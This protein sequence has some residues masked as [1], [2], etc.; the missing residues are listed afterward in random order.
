MSNQ[1]QVKIGPKFFQNEKRAYNSHKDALIRELIQ[2][3]V[4][5]KYSTKIHFTVN[6]DE[7]TISDNGTGMSRETL[8]KVFMNLGETTKVGE[9][10]CG[11]FG[12]ARNLICFAQEGYTIISDDYIV[13]GCGA[14]Y[15]I[16]DAPKSNG[17][18]F[19]IKTG[20]SA[21]WEERIKKILNKCSPRQTIYLNGEEIKNDRHRGRHIRNFSFGA[22]YVNHSDK[23]NSVDVRSNGVWMFSNYCDVPATIYVEVNP[24]ISKTVFTSNRDGLQ[25]EY[26]KE[27]NAFLKELATE[28]LSA[29][30]VKNRTF[31][32]FMKKGMGF[33]VRP[34]KKQTK[35]VGFEEFAKLAAFATDRAAINAADVNFGERYLETPVV[36]LLPV[37]KEDSMIKCS[38]LV[39]EIND[40]RIARIVE[41]F[42][43]EF[44][45][46]NE[47]RYKLLKVWEVI[48]R[49]VA[50]EYAELT[51]EEVVFGIGWIFKSGTVAQMRVEENMRYLLINPIDEE[52]KIKYSTV[53]RDDLIELIMTAIHECSHFASEGGY[54]DEIFA[55]MQTN[56]SI[57]VVQ[58]LSA[59][60]QE[61]KN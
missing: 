29:L 15:E 26:Q 12:I 57:K 51:G 24:E 60:I 47:T 1:Y 55:Q 40:A 38:I 18:T 35:E 50:A 2:N 36:P 54:H 46:K 10:T 27:L 9:D 31:I 3:A 44:L 8:L 58:N 61:I 25:Y 52:G 37:F 4:D 34:K 53:K 19:I 17:C 13:T 33:I 59:I 20:E 49:N 43:P 16:L 41:K 11:G 56:L 45:N 7:I 32:K 6:G 5:A 22:V 14:S 28:K 39:N 23:T 30:K 42:D 48:C 21:G